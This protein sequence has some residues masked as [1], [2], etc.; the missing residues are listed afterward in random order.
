MKNLSF[1]I[2]KEPQQIIE[3]LK[4]EISK[5][6]TF[7]LNIKEEENEILSFNLRKRIQFGEQI[8]HRNLVIVKGGISRIDKENCSKVDISFKQ[9]P[10]VII[11]KIILFGLG[12]ISILTGFLSS[13]S[14]IIPGI[15]LL[16]IG[17]ILWFSL[18]KSFKDNSEKYRVLLSELLEI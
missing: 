12:L 11:S 8:L 4:S 1:K 9:N 16:A 7:T 3:Q 13:T 5:S 17:F 2:N 15:I 10:L 14:F 18:N 6:G